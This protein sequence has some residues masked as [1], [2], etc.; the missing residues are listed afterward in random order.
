MLS[1]ARERGSRNRGGRG[2]ASSLIVALVTVERDIGR[3]EQII[4]ILEHMQ[5]H[6]EI[7]RR[8]AHAVD[9]ANADIADILEGME[10]EEFLEYPVTFTTY[11][12]RGHRYNQTWRLVGE[13]SPMHVTA[14]GGTQEHGLCEP[15]DALEDHMVGAPGTRFLCLCDTRGWDGTRPGERG[16]DPYTGASVGWFNQQI[17]FLKRLIS[18]LRRLPVTQPRAR[19]KRCTRKRSKKARTKRRR[20][21]SRRRK[22]KV[23]RTR[24]R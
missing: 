18:E 6:P 20:K 7:F 13:T 24:R 15:N 10:N 11:G 9:M 16:D 22:R 23:A 19:G 21:G 14:T 2:L 1:A 4:G 5:T 17:Q 3:L 12:G 8:D